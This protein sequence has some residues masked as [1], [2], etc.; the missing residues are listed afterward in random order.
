[1]TKLE[2]L[3]VTVEYLELSGGIHSIQ[4]IISFL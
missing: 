3:E 4:E 2:I 1:M